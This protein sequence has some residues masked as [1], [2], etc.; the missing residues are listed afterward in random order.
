M[1]QVSRQPLKTE[2]TVVDRL[3][4]KGLV[5]AQHSALPGG[6]PDYIAPE[7]LSA[8]QGTVRCSQGVV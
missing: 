7:L 1:R 4:S 3:D 2:L 8:I 6:T 5:P